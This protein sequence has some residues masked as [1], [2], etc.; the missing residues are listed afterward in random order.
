MKILLEF[1]AVRSIWN[2][3]SFYRLFYQDH[4][5]FASL[6]LSNYEAINR[7]EQEV[8]EYFNFASDVLDQWSQIEKEGKQ[9]SNPALWWIN[10]RGTEVRWSFEELGSLSRKA[11]NVLTDPCGLQK[12]DRVILILPR[13]PEWWL[14]NVACMRTGII[15]IPG[16]I[17]LTARDIF[18]RLQASKAKCI[19]TN[20]VLA[21]TVDTIVSKCQ[22]LKTKLIISENSR[23]GWLN[24]SELFKHKE[25]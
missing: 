13:I 3:K 8:P 12:G 22:F 18:Y 7:C 19:I 17:Q 1:Q 23:D 9:P 2:L 5:V 6:N 10:G 24:F 21:P 16:T 4:K 15:F 20:D 14:L 11:A 25:G